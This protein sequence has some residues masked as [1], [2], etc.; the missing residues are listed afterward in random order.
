MVVVGGSLVPEVLEDNW[1]KVAA[2]VTCVVGNAVGCGFL[3]V[4]SLVSDVA[5][6][7]VEAGGFKGEFWSATLRDTAYTGL[8]IAP[9]LIIVQA[10]WALT[11]VAGTEAALVTVTAS[12]IVAY[13]VAAGIINSMTAGLSIAFDVKS[14]EQVEAQARVES[15]LLRDGWRNQTSDPRSDSRSDSS[16]MLGNS[17]R[18]Q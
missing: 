2:G 18:W 13:K 12:E 8:A 17:E 9:G 14:R 7:A 11:A 4:G 5:D 15:N 1:T 6:N 16:D 10:P 3:I